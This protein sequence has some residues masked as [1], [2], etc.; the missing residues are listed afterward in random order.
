LNALRCPSE[1]SGVKMLEWWDG[2][3]I[4]KEDENRPELEF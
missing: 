1:F 4:S 2:E 3:V